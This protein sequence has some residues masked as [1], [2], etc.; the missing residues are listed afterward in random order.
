MRVSDRGNGRMPHTFFDPDL[1]RSLLQAIRALWRDSGRGCYRPVPFHRVRHAGGCAV[2]HGGMVVGFEPVSDVLAHP[3]RRRPLRRSTSGLRADSSLLR[4]QR[5]HGSFVGQPALVARWVAS[6][7]DPSGEQDRLHPPSGP[8]RHR[9]RARQ[10]FLP[11]EGNNEPFR[12]FCAASI[13]MVDALLQEARKTQAGH[14]AD[15][16]G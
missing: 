5:S 3:E 8:L 6:H 12:A 4:W 7:L 14:L 9:N 2:A 10:G 13:S 1:Q 16:T 15:N 11:S